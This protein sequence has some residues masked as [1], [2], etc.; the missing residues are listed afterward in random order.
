LLKR[1][2]MEKDHRV[3]L[4]SITDKGRKLLDRVFPLHTADLAKAMRGLS[5][6]EKQT[7]TSLLRK[8]QSVVHSEDR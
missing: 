1:Q 4:G 3:V 6:E 5:A 2:P 8:M 7:I